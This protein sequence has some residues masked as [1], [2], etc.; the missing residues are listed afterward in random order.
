MVQRACESSSARRPLDIFF[1]T[2][3][4]TQLWLKESERSECFWLPSPA[5]ARPSLRFCKTE[6]NFK[7]GRA[8]ASAACPPSP[9][10]LG[11]PV[12]EGSSGGS[13]GITALVRSLRAG[14]LG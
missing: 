11:V 1:V 7:I 14:S 12:L 13:D 5:G 6:N 10:I 9:L 4:I 8:C 3:R 2:Y